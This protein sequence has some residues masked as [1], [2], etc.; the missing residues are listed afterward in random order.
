VDNPTGGKVDEALVRSATVHSWPHS[1]G[2][3]PCSTSLQ[4]IL[5]LG[6]EILSLISFRTKRLLKW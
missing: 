2:R 4:S 5:H 1:N 6:T 3:C